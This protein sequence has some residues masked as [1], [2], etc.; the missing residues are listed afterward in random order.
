MQAERSYL[1]CPGDRPE[2]FGK[3]LASGAD[4][5][6]L[7]LEDAVHPAAKAAAR[8]SIVD[9]LRAA[10]APVMIRINAADSPWHEDDVAAL[11]GLP[12]LA[13]LMLP[14]AEDPATLAAVR[15]RIGDRPAL[16][17]LVETVR[18]VADLR[19]VAS[20][21][22]LQRIAFGSIDFCTETAIRGYGA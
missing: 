18:G 16:V 17:A 8:D 2:R 21:P 20:T 6:V 14:K 12:A 3:A 9:W 4:R 19:R 11:A 10:A 22:G 5:I 15:E 7:D 1:F 13:G